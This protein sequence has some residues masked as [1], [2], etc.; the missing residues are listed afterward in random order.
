MLHITLILGDAETT[1]EQET[2]EIEV[3]EKENQTETLDSDFMSTKKY[4]NEGPEDFEN[5]Y[6]EPRFI[7]KDPKKNITKV[8]CVIDKTYGPV[9]VKIIL[10]KSAC[11][12]VFFLKSRK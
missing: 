5:L 12:L 6:T 2:V 1:Q 11:S 9:E 3:L 10:K 4:K 8:N 7:I